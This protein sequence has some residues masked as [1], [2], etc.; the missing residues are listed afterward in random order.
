MT[1]QV[2]MYSERLANALR[3]ADAIRD[4]DLSQD[5]EI[6]KFQGKSDADD[7]TDKY[8]L[9]RG[10]PLYVLGKTASGSI[11]WVRNSAP[12]VGNPIYV[13]GRNASG[14]GW[15][16]VGTFECPTDEEPTEEEPI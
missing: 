3:K 9:I 11:G 4:V 12:L 1:D 6:T 16:A 14:F 15:V 7:N 2:V 8:G 5:T 13:W 10:A